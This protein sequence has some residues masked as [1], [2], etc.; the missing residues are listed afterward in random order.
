MQRIY[1]TDSSS[2]TAQRQIMWGLK[3]SC[4]PSG[5]RLQEEK[6]P[7]LL[8]LQTKRIPRI[9][10]SWFSVFIIK[11]HTD[12]RS[13]FLLLGSL[14]VCW[15]KN[16]HECHEWRLITFSDSTGQAVIR[17]QESVLFQHFSLIFAW[18][19]DAVMRFDFQSIIST[20]ISFWFIGW[21][22]FKC[23]SERHTATQRW[24]TSCP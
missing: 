8:P 11:Y 18:W 23:C 7:R 4:A 21:F 24:I 9:K 10:F 17:T 19:K 6:K 15:C 2:Y 20:Q 5:G 13:F 3:A 16:G 22:Y 1:N 14:V 12:V